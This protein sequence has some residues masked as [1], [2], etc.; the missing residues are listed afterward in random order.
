[1]KQ[2]LAFRQGMD[3]AFRE[4]DSNARHEV[5]SSTNVAP[6]TARP[7][8]IPP[9]LS[10]SDPQM[11]GTLLKR[12]RG[13]VGVGVGLMVLVLAVVVH[14]V[15]RYVG[16]APKRYPTPRK[17]GY[18]VAFHRVLAS[19]AAVGPFCILLAHL[20]SP[21][22][23]HTLVYWLLRKR[24]P[25]TLSWGIDWSPTDPRGGGCS[26]FRRCVARYGALAIQPV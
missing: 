5:P 16:L 14:G 8:T 2:R 3:E 6:A 19:P 1:M 22:F 18:D 4:T 15:W 7:S 9:P 17:D 25:M 13:L 21:G 12:H 20:L 24:F 11:A 26:L 23:T 10:S